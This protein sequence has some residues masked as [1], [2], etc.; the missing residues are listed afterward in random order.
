MSEYMTI[1]DYFKEQTN[2]IKWD[3]IYTL[4]YLL[5]LDCLNV[6]IC[7][8]TAFSDNDIANAVFLLTAFNSFVLS[9]CIIFKLVDIADKVKGLNSVLLHEIYRNKEND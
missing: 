9:Y 1:T 5:I 4:C 2:K 6:I 8:Y 7:V 3:Y